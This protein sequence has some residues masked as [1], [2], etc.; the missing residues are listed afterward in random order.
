MKEEGVKEMRRFA[1]VAW[2][3]QWHG[4][5]GWWIWSAH[6]SRAGAWKEMRESREKYSRAGKKSD[7][8]VRPYMPE[9]THV[10]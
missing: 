9:A 6:K 3:V 4:Q 5:D 1:L 2:V 10:E 7:F 8:R